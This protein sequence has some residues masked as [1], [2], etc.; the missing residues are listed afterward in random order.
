MAERVRRRRVRL[1]GLGAILK[2][3]IGDLSDVASKAQSTKERAE[4][5][6]LIRDLEKVREE[7]QGACRVWSRSFDVHE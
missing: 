2:D 1:K 7:I 5:T 6:R 3:T 4:L